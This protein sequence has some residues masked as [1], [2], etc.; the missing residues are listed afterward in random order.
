M[1]TIHKL[2]YGVCPTGM[3]KMS[4]SRFSPGRD[5]GNKSHMGQVL[6]KPRSKTLRVTYAIS[7]QSHFFKDE[8]PS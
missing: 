7:V 8:A 4:I 6:G 3:L 2:S 5:L 1:D